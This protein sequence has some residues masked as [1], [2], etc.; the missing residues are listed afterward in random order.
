MWID[1]CPNRATDTRQRQS[2]TFTCFSAAQTQT[3]LDKRVSSDTNE[4][5]IT[6]HSSVSL[7]HRSSLKQH[8]YICSYSQR[9]IVWLKVIHL[10]LMPK[11]DIKI[12]LHED[13]P[14]VNISKLNFW[15]VKCIA[16]NFIFLHPQ[17][18]EFQILSYH[19]K[20]YINGNIIY[21]AFRWCIHLN[22]KKMTLWLV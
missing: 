6:G 21:S 18:P 5:K 13:I 12:M 3:E 2:N 8:S 10:Y 15:L 11:I 1:C 17:I 22:L 16:K 9:Y 7:E 14:T 4:H 19:N 20:P